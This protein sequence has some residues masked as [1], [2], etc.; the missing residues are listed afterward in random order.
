MAHAGIL[1]DVASLFIETNENHH[2]A[3]IETEGVDPEWPLWYADYLHGQL[4]ELLHAELTK[5]EIIYLLL[6]L[7]KKRTAEAPGS[8]WPKYYA[9]ILADM[10]I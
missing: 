10:Y 3:F 5:S 1:E 4:G 6:M 7:E 8:N 9:N 2:K